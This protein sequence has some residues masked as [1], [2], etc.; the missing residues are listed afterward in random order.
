MNAPRQKLLLLSE[1]AIDHVDEQH[2][3]KILRYVREGRFTPAPIKIGKVY[4]VE[5]TA[6]LTLPEPALTPNERAKAK[7]SLYRHYGARGELL[8]VGISMHAL[9]RTLKHIETAPWFEQ[10]RTIHIE[11]FPTRTLALEMER[12]AIKREKPLHNIVHARKSK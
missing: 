5:A 10:V 6:R 4:Y 9:M 11:H 12:I 7:T 8:Y 1:W 3:K 2:A